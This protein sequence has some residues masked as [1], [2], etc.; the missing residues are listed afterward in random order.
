MRIT[1]QEQPFHPIYNYAV[2]TDSEEGL[3]LV[4]VNTLADGEP[5]NNFLK[6]D[7]TWNPNGLLNGASHI[8]LGGHLAYVTT[9]KGVVFLDLDDPLKPKHI[10]TVAL[11]DARATALQFRYLFVTDKTGLRVIDVTLPKKPTLLPAKIAL[12]DAQRV[13]LA[14]TYAYV[15]AGNEGLVIVDIEKPTAPFIYQKF[16]AGGQLNDARDVIVGSTNASLYAYVADGKNGLKVVQLTAPDT[17]PRFYGFSPEPKPNLIAWRKTKSPAIALSKGL[18]RDRG[19]DE[20]GG[21][22]A[23]FGRI[24]SRPFTRKEME[25]IYLKPDGNIWTVS[26]EIN[27]ADFVPRKHG[28]SVVFRTGAQK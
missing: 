9:P 3:I 18:D 10:A 15:A 16:T 7:L 21:Q 2:V 6:R 26:D 25:H 22:I 8:T 20:T 11:E 24:G 4:D 19:V 14:R 13:Y 28:N 17:Q 1:N 5:R 23:V 27:L 12:Q